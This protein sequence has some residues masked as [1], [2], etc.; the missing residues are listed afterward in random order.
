MTNEEIE[1]TEIEKPKKTRAGVGWMK[2][3]K[4]LEAR[5]DQLQGKLDEEVAEIEQPPE[6]NQEENKCPYCSSSVS[7]Y[8]PFCS[9]CGK[10]LNWSDE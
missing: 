2:K 5:F 7:E 3:Y 4:E 8:S 9:K 1:N 6:E 10:K